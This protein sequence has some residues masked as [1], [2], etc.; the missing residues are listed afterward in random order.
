MGENI[1]EVK[2]RSDWRCPCCRNICNC[3]GANC[4]RAKRNLAVT[5]QLIHEA[6]KQGFKSV[7]LACCRAPCAHGSALCCVSHLVPLGAWCQAPFFDSVKKPVL[8]VSKTN[9][10]SVKNKMPNKDCHLESVTVTPSSA[11]SK[12]YCQLLYTVLAYTDGEHRM[13]T[14]HN[15]DV[16]P[17]TCCMCSLADCCLADF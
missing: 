11:P 4:L 12:L 1:H 6:T 2:H 9:F 14:K 10:D 8:I 15:I 5:N 7:R 3:S 17:W 13:A 16:R